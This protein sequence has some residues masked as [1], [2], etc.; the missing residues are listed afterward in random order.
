MRSARL[1]LASLVQAIAVAI[2]LPALLLMFVAERVDDLADD[3][4]DRLT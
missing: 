3:L 4:W 1:V 2:A